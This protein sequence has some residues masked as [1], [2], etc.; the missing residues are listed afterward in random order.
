MIMENNDNIEKKIEA[1]LDSANSINDVK[2]SPFFK[3]QT[4]DRLFSEQSERQT[5]WFWFTPKL[6][7]ATLL[8]FLALNIY[9]FTQVNGV[10]YDDHITDFAETHGLSVPEDHSLFN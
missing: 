5:S 6:Q 4:L 7:L 8:C 10:S 2:V 9:T 1:V 3:D